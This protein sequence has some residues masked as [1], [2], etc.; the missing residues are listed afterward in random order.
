MKYEIEMTEQ[1]IKDLRAVRNYFGENDR[2]IFEH[3]AYAILDG[4]VKK[5]NTPRVSKCDEPVR[6]TTVCCETC[7]YYPPIGLNKVPCNDCI[8]YDEWQQTVC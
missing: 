8:E 2:T 7:K 6:E 4:I 3:K 1:D 5:L